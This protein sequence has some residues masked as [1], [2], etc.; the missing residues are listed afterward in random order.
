[1]AEDFL[2]KNFKMHFESDD[3]HGKPLSEFSFLMMQKVIVNGT[4]IVQK[5]GYI[6]QSIQVKQTGIHKLLFKSLKTQLEITKS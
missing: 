3:A 5:P 1:M 6:F 2:L 4:A